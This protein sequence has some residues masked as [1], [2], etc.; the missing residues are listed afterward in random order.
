M[1]Q[2]QYC[3][4]KC[5]AVEIDNSSIESDDSVDREFAR[6]G[7]TDDVL[8]IPDVVQLDLPHQFTLHLYP[9]I[10]G[11]LGDENG[12]STTFKSN[13]SAATLATSKTAPNDTIQYLVPCQ[14]PPPI[15][16][17]PVE[18]ETPT[19]IMID[20][21]EETEQAAE[22]DAPMTL[23][24]TAATSQVDSPATTS[25]NGDALSNRSKEPCD[26]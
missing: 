11:I 20:P 8:T 7:F 9:D 5:C 25:P 24:P 17:G 22:A 14:K 2:Y 3:P 4:N 10:N 1:D 19:I 23:S 18:T 12:D 15:L 16:P 6:C 26:D 13:L 21:V